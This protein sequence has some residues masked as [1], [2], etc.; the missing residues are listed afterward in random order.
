MIKLLQSRLLLKFLLRSM[1]LLFISI[2][3]IELLTYTKTSRIIER[4][5]TEL[6]RTEVNNY[7]A[8]IEKQLAQLSID[9][10]V[11]SQLPAVSDMLINTHYGL[12]TEAQQLYAPIENFLSV[13]VDRNTH[14]RQ[15]GICDRT[16]KLVFIYPANLKPLS[17]V[18]CGKGKQIKLLNQGPQSLVVS[19]QPIIRSKQLIGSAFAI[20]NITDTFNQISAK[21]IVD[22]GFLALFD[23]NMKLLTRLESD[24]LKVAQQL[25][26]E[27][28]EHSAM[29]SRTIANQQAFIYTMAI[30][31]T[32]WQLFAVAFT[33]EMFAELRQVLYLVTLVVLVVFVVEVVFLS[34]FTNAL[35]IKPIE[36]LLK[37]TQ[38]ILN[39][40]F[41]QIIEVRSNDEVGKL[42]QAF[43]RMTQTID[44]QMSELKQLNQNLKLIYSIFETGKE[45]VVVADANWQV[46]NVNR[47]FVRQFGYSKEEMLGTVAYE[48]LSQQDGITSKVLDN[49]S[50]IGHWQGEILLL[51]KQGI[52]QAQLCSVN[53]VVDEQY[54]TSHHIMLFSDISQLKETQ[55]QLEKLA[56]YDEL[57]GLYN[58]YQFNIS[59]HLAVDNAAH[60]DTGFALFFIDLDNFK[61]IND[62]MG[63]DI[64]D[65]FLKEVARRLSDVTRASDIVSRFGGDEFVLLLQNLTDQGNIS[66]LADKIRETLNTQFEVQSK[67][68]YASASMGIA[69]YPNDGLTP[70]ELLKAAD[71]AMYSAK[72]SGKNAYQFFMPKM[73]HAIKEKLN[74]EEHLNMAMHN[75]EF[76]FFYQA[77]TDIHSDEVIKAEALLRWRKANGQLISPFEFLAIAEESGLIVPISYQ[78]FEKGCAFINH[79]EKTYKKPLQISFNLSGKQFRQHDLAHKLSDIAAKYQIAASNIEFEITES[80]IMKDPQLAKVICQ[81]IKD[82]GFRLSLDDFGTGYSSLSY[83]RD[84]PI[85]CIKVDR[86]FVE[87]ID[88]NITNQAIIHAVLSIAKSL[89]LEVICEGVETYTQVQFLQS[90]G[91]KLFQGYYYSKPLEQQAYEHYVAES[92]SKQTVT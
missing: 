5:I 1:L 31:S 48:L 56:H 50:R 89:D 42:T 18:K 74:F 69:L 91:V 61:Y 14:Y 79:L 57:T 80:V 86:C 3:C 22:S 23:Q 84:Y 44:T 12:L 92:M 83:I 43:N 36:N 47:A 62:T 60:S 76:E 2:A 33:K 63:H 16:N 85:D 59:L 75:D 4:Q 45:G 17:S 73:N 10:Q 41:G 55:K 54:N 32:G 30:P 81:Q 34:Y 90:M 13:Q 68:I 39:G 35:V 27:G 65:G 58:R 15:F 52:S 67:Q 53:Q 78:I 64:G 88:S 9:T 70:S 26:R 46:I 87:D 20:L 11:L 49:I 37:A 19:H 21:H 51:N 38:H 82:Y 24:N 29:S 8:D 25:N 7:A 71:I 40:N 66:I 77:K 72:D 6:Q 28:V